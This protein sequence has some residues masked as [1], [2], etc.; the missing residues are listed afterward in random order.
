MLINLDIPDVEQLDFCQQLYFF[1]IKLM[2]VFKKKN[3]K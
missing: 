2:L 3:C 1:K